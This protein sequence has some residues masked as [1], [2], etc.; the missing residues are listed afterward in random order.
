MEY[1]S[2]NHGRRIQWCKHFQNQTTSFRDNCIINILKCHIYFNFNQIEIAS[3]VING[4]PFPDQ[5][6]EEI[7]KI[8]QAVLKLWP[9][10]NL[11]VSITQ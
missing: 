6:T 9:Y 8:G 5:E 11:H 7:F 1:L 3:S 4:K 2:W 10:F